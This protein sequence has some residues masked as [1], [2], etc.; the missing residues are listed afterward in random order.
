MEYRCFCIN[1]RYDTIHSYGDVYWDEVT[2]TRRSFA[3][4]NG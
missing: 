4:H 1:S 2:V 3:K